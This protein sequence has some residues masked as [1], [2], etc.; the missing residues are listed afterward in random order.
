MSSR[1]AQTLIVSKIKKNPPKQN[2]CRTCQRGQFSSTYMD[3]TD[4]NDQFTKKRRNSYGKIPFK[5]YEN[6]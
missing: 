6:I 2:T 1:N 4:P 5:L 3:A